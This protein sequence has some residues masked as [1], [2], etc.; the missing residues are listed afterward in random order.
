[1]RWRVEVPA[2]D[3]LLEVEPALEGQEMDARASVGFAYWE[4]LCFYRGT[5]E[6]EEIRGEGYVELTGYG[7]EDRERR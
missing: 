2:E 3:L 7:D 4:G 6:G 1:V 5:W